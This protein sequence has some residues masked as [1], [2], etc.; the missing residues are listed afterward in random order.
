MTIRGSIWLRRAVLALA[1][2][3]GVWT[4]GLQPLIS[5]EA[6]PEVR[7]LWVLRTS[8]SSPSSIHTLVRTA[9]DHGF[10]T[11]LVQVRGRGDA[12]Y[13]SELEPR[14]AD[15]VR[16]PT[17]FDPLAT[18]IAD[19]HQAGLRVHAW[20]NLNLVS[21]AVELPSA[22]DH[23]IYRHPEWLMVP[24]EI[25]QELRTIDPTSPGYVG[26]LARWVRAQ[27]D[28]LEG[29]YV[30]P[31]QA[32]ATRHTQAVVADVA[33]RYDVDGIHLDY[34]RYP[35]DHFDYSRF[36]IAAFRTEMRSKLTPAIRQELDEQEAVDLF[37]YPD[38][39]P[40]EWKTF[41]RAQLSAMMARIRTAVKAARPDA[42]LTIAAAPDAQE[43]FDQRL[44]DW[45]T[46]LERHVIDAVCPMAY[47][48]EPDR[49]AEQIAAARDIAGG[50]VVWAGI[51]AYRL[52]PEQTIE[53]IQAA[54][55]LGAAG[56]I[57][58][59][60]DSLT[61]SKEVPGDYLD[62]VSRGAMGN[63]GVVSR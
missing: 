38:R 61:A 9:A 7:A 14:A 34:A 12:Y 29:L 22:R 51:G 60:Y 25:A 5:A 47:T 24:R 56:F 4:I 32:D 57:L 49:F 55:R 50:N 58:F 37:A 2:T 33:R 59:S 52:K 46:W 31:I 53:N 17:T 42:F 1:A 11:L 54:R 48:P 62:V 28:K 10:N 27:P 36:A 30:S 63:T 23:V 40:D 18:V 26:K 44:Q 41:R 3:A 16:Q 8:L 15:L 35:S 43:A 6:R 45:R 20:I 19:A 13:T 39:F 21:S